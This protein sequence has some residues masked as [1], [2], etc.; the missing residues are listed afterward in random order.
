MITSRAFDIVEA[1]ASTRTMTE[2]EITSM[3]QTLAAP[4]FDHDCPVG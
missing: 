1:Q 4:A 3:V 2:E